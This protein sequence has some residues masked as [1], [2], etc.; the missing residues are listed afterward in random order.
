MGEPWMMFTK[1]QGQELIDH[2]TSTWT[3][4]NGVN[5]RK[6]TSKTDSS[7]Y[8]F[9]P[10]GGYWKDT[11]NNNSRTSGRYCSA[12]RASKY[13][14]Y[15]LIFDVGDI[16]IQTSKVY[17]AIRYYGNSIHPVAKPKPW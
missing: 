6:F 5:G 13:D 9:L 14:S 2:T 16:K 17:L 4:I 11:T 15:N 8:I 3:S 7:K 10:A 1:T 12:T